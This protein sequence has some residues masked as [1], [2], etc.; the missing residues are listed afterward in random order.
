ML[1][2]GKQASALLA[3]ILDNII[4][5][6]IYVYIVMRTLQKKLQ[7]YDTWAITKFSLSGKV[8]HEV[9]K[10]WVYINIEITVD[11]KTTSG[12]GRVE[13]ELINDKFVIT[14]IPG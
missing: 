10:F 7:K 3:R 1:S 13:V 6:R 5:V 8:E 2:I 12:N 9:G 4:P 14:G 11:G